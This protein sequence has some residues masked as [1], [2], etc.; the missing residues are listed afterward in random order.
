MFATSHEL[1]ELAARVGRDEE[2]QVLLLEDVYGLQHRIPRISG[3]IESPHNTRTERILTMS[4]STTDSDTATYTATLAVVDAKGGPA[5]LDPGS[6]A[7][8]VDQP[9]VV[10]A[11]TPSADGSEATFTIGAAGE[12]TITATVTDQASSG[13]AAFTVP[14]AVTVVGGEPVSGTITV[15]AA[16]STST[17]LGTPGVPAAPA[18]DPSAPADPTTAG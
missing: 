3:R 9:T 18:V 13:I 4:L 5:T 11:L 16:P 6:V 14:F 15:A 12:A 8:T 7:W 17:G 10:T 1:R 2:V